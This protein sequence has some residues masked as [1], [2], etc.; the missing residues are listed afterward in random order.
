MPRSSKNSSR[1]K[2]YTS[3]T[4]TSRTSILRR[5]SKKVSPALI[6]FI[7]GAIL[8]SISLLYHFE[9]LVNLTF[10]HQQLP[11]TQ[12][13]RTNRPVEIV[14]DK[15]HVDLPVLE[16]VI[17]NN[18]WQIADDGISHLT[19]SAR[20]GEDGTI[21]VYG[22]NTNDRFGPLLWLSVG[23]KVTLVTTDE[24]KYTYKIQKI[25]TVDP[26]DTKI[27]TS[28]K[29]STLILYTCTGFA[30]LKRYVLI[31]KPTS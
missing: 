15:V 14:I 30:D 17:A 7:V 9:Q 24:K 21:I 1:T 5:K 13:E 4:K 23:D 31:A 16:T 18:T 19:E 29:G 11:P 10:Y 25:V 27:L 26:S 22:H 6:I 12:T 28:Q 2:K 8:L 3:K 20:P